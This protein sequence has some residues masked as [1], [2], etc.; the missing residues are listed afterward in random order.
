[1]SYNHRH[2]KVAKPRALAVI[3]ARRISVIFFTLWFISVM[4]FLVLLA[5]YIREQTLPIMETALADELEHQIKTTDDAQF[6]LNKMRYKP[7][8]DLKVDRLWLGA[9]VGLQVYY[10]PASSFPPLQLPEFVVHRAVLTINR[11]GIIQSLSGFYTLKSKPTYTAL[12]V[13]RGNLS[14]VCK[15]DI[16]PTYLTFQAF[17]IPSGSFP[18]DNATLQDSKLEDAILA[19]MQQKTPQ[20][21]LEGIENGEYRC[22]SSYLRQTSVIR[23]RW[24]L[25]ENGKPDTFVLVAYGWSPLEVAARALVPFSLILFIIYLLLGFI[26]WL[27]IY[28]AL[29]HPIKKLCMDLEKSPLAVSVNEQDYQFPYTE[30]QQLIADYLMRRQMQNAVALALTS[31]ESTNDTQ[32][33]YALNVVRRKLNPFLLSKG[34]IIQNDDKADGSVPFDQDNVV[35]LLQNLVLKSLPYTNT[36]GKIVLRTRRLEFFLLV[37]IDVESKMSLSFDD[38]SLLW[39]EFYQNTN[40]QSAIMQ[41]LQESIASMPGTFLNIRRTKPG[42][43]FTVGFYSSDIDPDQR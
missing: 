37:E 30:L 21:L 35:E 42:L 23:G 26:I 4:V 31:T 8:Y 14:I 38:C 7:D 36:A 3:L 6:S 5:G 33:L 41:C 13:F 2:R 20:D 19:S 17:Q 39:Q 28:G 10:S 25:T 27:F 9:I 16:P 15:E 24:L 32:L 29:V 22:D 12:T 34:L 43:C 40:G 1:M 18:A 11:S